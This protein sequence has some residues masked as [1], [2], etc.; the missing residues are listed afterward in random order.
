MAL[1]LNGKKKLANA[2][3]DYRAGWGDGLDDMKCMVLTVFR[4]HPELSRDEI[5]NYIKENL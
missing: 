1:D 5:Y 4:E 3:P 2:T